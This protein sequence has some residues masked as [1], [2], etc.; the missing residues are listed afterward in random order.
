MSDIVDTS[1]PAADET[2]SARSKNTHSATERTPR[3]HYIIDTVVIL[4]MGAILFW[5]ASSQFS[6]KYNDATRYQCYGIAFWQGKAALVV[7]GL[8]SNAQSQCA[9]IDTSSSSTLAQKLQARHFPS[10]LVSLVQSQSST[11]A[12]HA[13]PPEYPLLTLAIFSPPLFASGLGY[14]VVFA[15]LMFVVAAIIYLLIARYRSR[16]AATAFAFYIALGS[17]ATALGR[18]DLVPAAL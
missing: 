10:F 17:W 9:F 2:G 13:L 16:P 4:A 11:Q 15:L 12:F 7:Q 1:A 5:G 18:F 6:N 3:W 8:D 14:Q